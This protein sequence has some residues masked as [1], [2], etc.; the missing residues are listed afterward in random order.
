MTTKKLSRDVD[1]MNERH[2][3]RALRDLRKE[4]HASPDVVAAKAGLSR[5]QVGDLERGNWRTET[6]TREE[7]I[8]LYL[9]AIEA[10]KNPPEPKK[11]QLSPRSAAAV[12]SMLA[13]SGVWETDSRIRPSRLKRF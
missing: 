11:K 8:S 13:M 3:G 5:A 12:T 2:D 1:A 4:I 6:P 10:I 9:A 7:A